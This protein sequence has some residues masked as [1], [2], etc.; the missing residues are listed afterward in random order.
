MTSLSVQVNSGIFNGKANIRDI[1]DP[2]NPI[3][4]DGNGTLQVT[5]TDTGSDGDTIGIT[6]WDKN[7]GLWFSSNWQTASLPKTAE[8]KLGASPGGGNVVVL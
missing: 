2:L 7:G 8:Q 5:M 6:L 3:S 1:T 4:L